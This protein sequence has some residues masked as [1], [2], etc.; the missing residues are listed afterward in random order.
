MFSSDLG[1]R[2]VFDTPEIFFSLPLFRIYSWDGWMDAD[3]GWIGLVG[4]VLRRERKVLG[5]L[6]LGLGDGRRDGD[7]QTQASQ[8]SKTEQG[9]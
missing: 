8:T 2:C 9:S 5:G 3:D 4:G 6:R 1:L 7:G